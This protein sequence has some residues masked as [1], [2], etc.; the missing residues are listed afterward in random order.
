MLRDLHK[1]WVRVISLEIMNVLGISNRLFHSRRS[2]ID[3]KVPITCI[4][5]WICEHSFLQLWVWMG[6]FVIKEEDRR[7]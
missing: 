2:Q 7:L 3:Q 4:R 1:S 6:M 5:K